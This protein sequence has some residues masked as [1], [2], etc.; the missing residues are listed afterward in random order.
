M[1]QHVAD[2]DVA[3]GT[4]GRHDVPDVLVAQKDVGISCGIQDH[5]SSTIKVP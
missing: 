4:D 5:T 3:H 1:R 2:G